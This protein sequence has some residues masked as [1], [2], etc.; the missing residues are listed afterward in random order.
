M[1]PTD[2]DHYDDCYIY[3]MVGECPHMPS[4][5][6]RCDY[7]LRFSSKVSGHLTAPADPYIRGVHKIAR[8]HLGSRVRFWHEINETNDE[9]QRGCYG[10]QEVHAAER[11]LKE[12]ETRQASGLENSVS[13]DQSQARSILVDVAAAGPAHPTPA[14]VIQAS[15]SVQDAS[16]SQ[17]ALS[18]PSPLPIPQTNTEESLYAIRPIPGKGQG[19]IA[20][21]KI[22][23]G[24]RILSEVPLFKVPGDE[25]DLK[26]VND[27]VIRALRSLNKDGQRAFL[28]LHNAYEKCPSPFLGIARTNV[29]PLGSEAREGGLFLEASRINH[30]C[31]HNAQNTWNAN[32]GQLTIHALRDIEVGQEITIAY[33]DRKMGRA[34][35]RLHL[36][37]KFFF[38]CACEL[39][40]LPPA[41][42]EESD[43][44]LSK[45][46]F[47]D[48]CLNDTDSGASGYDEGLYLVRTILRLLEEEGVWDASVPRA[49]YDAF[50]IATANRD[51]ARA[52]VFAERA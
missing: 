32:I 43:L 10:W 6:N 34:E 26:V 24:T 25:L 36:K 30:S 14:T 27:H 21:S 37:E 11:K 31:R 18:R 33:L 8:K 29:L 12:R 28:A 22:H 5:S 45:I 40:M 44:R 17:P 50:Q 39:C 35:R 1:M 19:L 16:S 46:Q 38:D 4:N 48:D 20:T 52:K 13:G 15:G 9:R 49:Y 3:F 42:R 7:F 23:K 2:P 51:D 47:I 41:Q